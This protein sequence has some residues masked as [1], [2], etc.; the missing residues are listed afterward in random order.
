MK[1]KIKLTENQLE[2]IIAKSIKRAHESVASS[3]NYGTR[4]EYLAAVNAFKIVYHYYTGK[5]IK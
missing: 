3:S 1:T 4:K 2:S 5:K